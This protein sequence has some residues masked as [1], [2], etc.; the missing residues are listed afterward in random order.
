MRAEQGREIF[1]VPGKVS[2]HTS[3]GTN[4]LIKDGARLVSSADDI[5]EELKIIEI[6]YSSITLNRCR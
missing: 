4:D 1:A 6:T 5:L 2:S 3:A